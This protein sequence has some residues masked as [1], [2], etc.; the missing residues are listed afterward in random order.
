MVT[1][2]MEIF[3]DT[4]ANCDSTRAPEDCKWRC[5]FTARANEGRIV[6]YKSDSASW[7]R[8]TICIRVAKRKLGTGYG[9]I[10]A[11]YREIRHVT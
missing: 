2:C 4:I 11:E 8:Q 10:D 1:I 3:S 5:A 7:R 6:H 9:L